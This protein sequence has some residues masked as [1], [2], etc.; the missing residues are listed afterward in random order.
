MSERRIVSTEAAPAAIGP[1]SQAVVHGG[2]VY[3][4]GQIPLD[5]AT[6]E[7][8]GDGD[9]A[10]EAE[11]VMKNLAAVLAAAGSGFE[12]ALRC[13]VFLADMGDYVAVNEVYAKYF[14]DTNAP[15]RFAVQAAGLP[16]GVKVEIA[17]IAAVP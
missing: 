3:T 8:V 15:P 2:V 5:P 7:I 14:D 13:D 1:Y 11:Q 10:A 4:A 16:K 9:A 6:M 17:C 12:H